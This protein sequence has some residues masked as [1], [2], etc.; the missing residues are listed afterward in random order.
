MRGCVL[1]NI[2]RRP[3]GERVH[4]HGTAAA[5][6]DFDVFARFALF[7][8][9]AESYL[10]TASPKY[11]VVLGGL[12]TS[13]KFS[14][15]LRQTFYGKSSILVFPGVSGFGPYN[16][17]VKATPI[18]DLEFGYDVTEWMNVSIGANNLFDKVPETPQLLPF[19]VGA[20]VS[21][22]ENGST[23]YNSPYGHG[24]YGSAGGYYY[25]RLSFKF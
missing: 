10:E 5:I 14:A 12:F 24:A 11:K 8:P 25:A 22:Y 17:V 20:G 7:T 2:G 19:A 1:R 9:Q 3:I 13:G 23:T 16:G 4:F 15:N 21:P 18:T 6:E